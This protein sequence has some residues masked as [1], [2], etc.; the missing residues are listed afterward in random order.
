MGHT[1]GASL[2]EQVATLRA[3]YNA[4]DRRVSS[5]ECSIPSVRADLDT[6][7]RENRRSIH[8]LRNGQQD[9]IDLFHKLDIK[10]ARA[11][12]YAIGAG[13]V[14]ALISRLIDHIWK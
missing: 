12:G 6:K 13:A 3:D 1:E 11:S 10:F 9:I 5:V 4:L 8:D 7:H 2:I 14:I